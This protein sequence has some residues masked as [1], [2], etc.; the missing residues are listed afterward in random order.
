[1]PTDSQGLQCGVDS[2]VLGKPFL[3]FFD[4]QKCIDPLVPINGCPTPQVCV[5]KCPQTTFTY[6]TGRG[7]CNAGNF[8]EIK[9]QLICTRSVQ[10]DL[11]NSCDQVETLMASDECAHWYLKSESCE[12][13]FFGLSPLCSVCCYR[14]KKLVCVFCFALLVLSRDRFVI[15]TYMC[16]TCIINALECHTHTT[17]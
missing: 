12:F 1:M 17:I 7:Q 3:M 9:R 4:L 11:I 8:A 15:F 10:M 16:Y 2:Q 6:E 14:R 13:A 5:E